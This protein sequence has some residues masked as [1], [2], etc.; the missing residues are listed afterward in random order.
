[1]EIRS[2]RVIRGSL[3]LKFRDA[4][5]FVRAQSF[6]GIGT[7][8]RLRE[9]F[10]FECESFRLASLKSGL[11]RPLDQPDG[12]ARLVRGNELTRIIQHLIEEVFAFEDFADQSELESFLESDHSTGRCK[13]DRACFSN[14]A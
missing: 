3:S 2:I 5:L 8:E 13:F 10:A 4:L 11:N 7:G 6:G 1:M 14:Q 12:F 9:Q